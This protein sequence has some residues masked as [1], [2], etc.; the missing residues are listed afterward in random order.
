LVIGGI[1]A[2]QDGVELTTERNKSNPSGPA[3][4]LIP[5]PPRGWRRLF[6]IGPGFL[7]MVSA[8]GSGE[9]LFTPRIGAIYGYS[10]LWALILAVLLKW[11]INREIGRYAVCTGN[12]I[13]Q[14]F[15]SLPGPGNWAVWIIVLPQLLVAISAIAGMAGA[16][17]TAL[18]LVLPGDIRIWMAASLLTSSSLVFL[19]RYSVVEKVAA[20]T[21]TSLALAAMAAALTVL[22]DARTVG[23]GLIPQLPPGIDYGEVLPW[24]GFML[25]GAAGLMW[26][27]YWVPAKGLGAAGADGSKVDPN[28][29]APGDKDS[30]KGWIGQMTLDNSIAVIGTLAITLA[31]LVLGAEIL[32]PEG[33][34]PEEKKVAGVLGRLLGD[35]WGPIGF[36]F[37]VVGV[38][39]GFWDTILSDQDGH[40]RLLSDGTRILLRPF[41]ITGRWL[42]EPHLRRAFLIFPATLL[43]LAL[44]LAIGDPVGLLKLAGAIEAA[45][46][47]FVTVLVLYLNHR[48][49]PETLRPS[50]PVFLVTATAGIFFAAFT[51]VYLFGL[52]R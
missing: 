36:W 29:L 2:L 28:Q 7:W 16:A 48:A 10:L 21:A 5:V 49:L 42:G 32:R 19:G 6:W 52:F 8:A 11:F 4:A 30:L 17:A 43:P 14:G 41:R 25:S 31:F 27:S 33:L 22:P 20:I 47:P 12:S 34:V 39:V 35:V 3:S 40:S 26:Y 24:L 37:M 23:V 18:V 9:L 45:H 44:Y 50:P 15:A 38:F 1:T 51:A 46:I 13:L